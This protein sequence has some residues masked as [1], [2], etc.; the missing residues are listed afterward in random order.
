MSKKVTIGIPVYNEIQFIRHTLHS[1]IGQGAE[2]I[3]ISDNAS[4]DGTSEVCQEFAQKYPQITYYRYD[5][6]QSVEDNFFNCL[7]RAENEYFMIMGGHDLLSQNYVSALRHILDTTEAV[8][9]YTNAVHLSHEYA[10]KTFYSYRYSSLLQDENPSTRVFATIEH[11]SN[12][13]LYYGLIRKEV[14]LA[15]FLRCKKQ[16]YTGIDHAIL[17]QIAAYGSMVLCP[18]ATFYRIDPPRNEGF[19]EMWERV[20]RAYHAQDYNPEKHIPELIP[21]G[22]AHVQY[23]IART[24][25]QTADNPKAYLASVVKM[26][27]QRWAINERSF[28]MLVSELSALARED[29]ILLGK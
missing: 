1:V 19:L 12:C 5:V 2:Q 21:L 29:G 14:F 25:A 8:H 4:T 10:F 6:T 28:K 24:V 17:S 26:L 15:A 22:I 11:L 9:A 13:S 18:A 20:L 27:L 23:N 16:K 7:Q 3:F